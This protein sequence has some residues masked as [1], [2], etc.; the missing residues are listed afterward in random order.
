MIITFKDSSDHCPECATA[1]NK[2]SIHNYIQNWTPETVRT[3]CFN[4]N[5]IVKFKIKY[6]HA[7][8]TVDD[9][10]DG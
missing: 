3:H 10:P 9:T 8:L 6:T 7:E 1:L 5:R 2:P 4:C